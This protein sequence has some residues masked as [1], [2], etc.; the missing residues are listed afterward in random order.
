VF[1]RFNRIESEL[2]CLI[3]AV[4]NMLAD[5]R[6]VQ[7]DFP[8]N[9]GEDADEDEDPEEAAH[10]ELK[11]LCG[12]RSRFG[13][14]FSQLEARLNG[15]LED[16]SFEAYTATQQDLEDLD[17]ILNTE[18]ASLPLVELDPEY[19]ETV[20]EYTVQSGQFGADETP[21]LMPIQVEDDI[22]IYWD[23]LADYYN[24]SSDDPVEMTLSETTFLRLWSRAQRARWTLWIDGQ[25]QKKMADFTEA[26]Q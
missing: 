7:P 6:E 25:E 19:F 3:L 24:S 21:I 2:D 23:P 5:Y 11:I 14:N 9:P 4:K 10:E 18:T 8:I 22:V 12:H 16:T 1:S 13:G 17:E 20:D 26:D 15:R